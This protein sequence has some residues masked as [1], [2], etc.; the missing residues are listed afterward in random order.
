MKYSDANPPIQCFMNQSNWVKGALKNGK[1][2][3]ILWHDTAAGNPY[4]KRYVQPDDNAPDREEMLQLLGVNKYKNDWNHSDRDAGVNCWVGKLADESVTTVQVGPWTTHAWGCGG[5]SL[6]SCNGY[7]KKNGSTQ[8]VPEFWIQFEICD[9]GYE[10][11]NSNKDYFLTAYK[12]ACEITAYLCKKFNIDPKGMVDFAGIKVPTILCHQDSYR[13]KLGSDHSDVLKWFKLYGYTMDTVRN[14]VANLLGG[15]PSTIK[16]GDLV[17]IKPGATYWSGKAIPKWVAEQNWYVYDI[18]G[19]RAVLDENEAGTS[20]IMSPINVNNL[21]LV[22]AEI[23]PE[24]IPEPTPAPTP[25]PIPD[26]EPEPIPDP[27]PEPDPNPNDTDEPSEKEINW[28]VRMIKAFV[29]A[30]RRIFTKNR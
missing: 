18:S 21:V 25:E 5:D 23:K 6:G 19:Q 8:W 3:G 9:D 10:S 12:E 30:L 29:E 11:G 26:P 27:E 24:P 28:F 20:H 7:V 4:I 16:V 13:K 17:S 22:Q 14:D 1:P 2:V 15:A